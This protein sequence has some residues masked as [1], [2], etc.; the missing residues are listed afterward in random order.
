MT[1]IHASGIGTIP[2][3]YLLEI[4]LPRKSLWIA[5]KQHKVTCEHS[6]TVS[7]AHTMLCCPWTDLASMQDETDDTTSRMGICCHNFQPWSKAWSWCLTHRVIEDYMQNVLKTE[8]EAGV[9]NIT[10]INKD[11]EVSEL[12]A[13][14][15]CQKVWFLPLSGSQSMPGILQL[16]YVRVNSS[17]LWSLWFIRD[18]GC[19]SAWITPVYIK[20]ILSMASFPFWAKGL[21]LF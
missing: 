17:V 18:Q 21:R 20:Q 6:V 8:K 10:V 15:K 4:L 3:K 14:H 11:F 9:C 7:W 2:H 13:E 5:E 16:F 19:K 12:V 1:T